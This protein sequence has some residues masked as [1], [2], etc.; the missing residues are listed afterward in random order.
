MPVCVPTFISSFQKDVLVVR[1]VKDVPMGGEI[2]NCYGPHAKRMGY[3]E[4]QRCLKE[5]YFFTCGCEACLKG[6]E[7]EMVLHAY[8]C[9]GCDGPTCEDIDREPGTMV[10]RQCG[11]TCSLDRTQMLEAERLF[12]R[13]YQCLQEN[14][15]D[16]ALQN[17]QKCLELQKSLL[18]RNNRKLSETQDC[19]ARCHATKGQFHQASKYIEESI[20]TVVINYGQESIEAANEFQKLSEILINAQEWNRALVANQKAVHIFEMN[21]GQSHDSVK[22]LMG[23]QN[24]LSELIKALKI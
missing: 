4:R 15:V 3:T 7:A 1:A 24:E 14:R 11:A 21:Y 6:V 5:Q 16:D 8:R 23:A 2:F 17:L 12:N 13:G 19:L 18:Y 20:G 22:I 9:S 10:C